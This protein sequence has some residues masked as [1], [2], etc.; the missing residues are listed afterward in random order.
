MKPCT[1]SR[2]RSINMMTKVHELPRH[3]ELDPSVTNLNMGATHCIFSVTFVNIEQ[4]SDH[5]DCRQIP[6]YTF[7]PL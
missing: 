7:R 5:A 4:E 2:S 1:N 3:L 6:K